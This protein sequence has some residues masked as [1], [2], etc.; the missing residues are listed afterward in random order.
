M[1]ALFGVAVVLRVLLVLLCTP[2]YSTFSSWGCKL[3]K[4][5]FHL[6]VIFPVRTLRDVEDTYFS[7]AKESAKLVITNGPMKLH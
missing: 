1:T 3:S 6:N 2:W 4:K 5:H 7:S